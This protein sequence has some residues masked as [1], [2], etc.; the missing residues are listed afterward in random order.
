MKN[1]E[2]PIRFRTIL[3]Y[4]RGNIL[5]LSIECLS[6]LKINNNKILYDYLDKD[7]DYYGIDINKEIIFKHKTKGR[8][9]KQCNLLNENIPFSEKFDCCVLIETLEHLFNPIDTLKKCYGVL[10]KGGIVIGSVPNVVC[11]SSFIYDNYFFNNKIEYKIKQPYNCGHWHVNSFDVS[12][13]SF[14]LR[15]S[16]FK[17]KIIKKFGCN[18]KKF[19]I[20][21]PENKLFN[22]FATYI[23]FVGEK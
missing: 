18:I 14:A 21:L 15:C 17:I 4:L 10:K 6:Y 7:I 2:I 22:I 12:T 3:P 5:D 9:V 11:M 8:N 16:G 23:L 20:N 19:G 13:L 1:I